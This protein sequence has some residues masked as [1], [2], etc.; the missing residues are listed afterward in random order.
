MFRDK[1]G[2]KMAEIRGLPKFRLAISPGTTHLGMMQRTDWMLQTITDFLDP[3][4]NAARN[5]GSTSFGIRMTT[6][7]KLRY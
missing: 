3:G 5:T 7:F 6:I 1:G 4:L 2:G